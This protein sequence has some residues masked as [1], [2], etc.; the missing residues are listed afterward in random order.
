MRHSSFIYWGSFPFRWSL[1]SLFLRARHSLSRAST[2][3]YG[4][5]SYNYQH[6]HLYLEI[7]IM[8]TTN[9]AKTRLRGRA[10]S[11]TR[12]HVARRATIP[13]RSSGL[14]KTP[15]R[16]CV[17]GRADSS[18]VRGVHWL[19]RAE[20]GGARTPRDVR[21]PRSGRRYPKKTRGSGVASISA[22]VSLPPWAA[23]AESRGWTAETV[24]KQSGSRGPP[25]TPQGPD[26]GQRG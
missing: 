5:Q 20:G 6:P 21:T 12:R 23:A 7:I 24:K 3:L 22:A 1:F 14:P 8:A 9:R 11:P 16:H 26:G 25:L 13:T 17:G 19:C 15:M 2:S 18:E 4:E 10:Q